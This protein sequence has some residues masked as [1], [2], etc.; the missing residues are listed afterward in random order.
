MTESCKPIATILV[1]DDDEEDRMLIGEAFKN[2]C[3][4]IKL[5]FVNDG[6][7]LFEH[8]K[9]ARSPFKGLILLDMNMP[10]MNGTEALKKKPAI[11]RAGLENAP[12]P[13]PVS[14]ENK[15]KDK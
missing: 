5:E 1:A 8:L 9:N 10:R 7:E 4:C 3:D 2:H 6:I 13:V 11:I 14:P 15:G 12:R